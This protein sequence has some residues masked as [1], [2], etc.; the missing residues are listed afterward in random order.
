MN[1]LWAVAAGVVGLLIGL[2]IGLLLG[3]R[4][5]Y[6]TGRSAQRM[7]RELHGEPM[8]GR[9]SF[10]ADRAEL[11]RA[12]QEFG[13]PRTAGDRPARPAPMGDTEDLRKA[14]ERAPGGHPV[15]HTPRRQP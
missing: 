8:K 7:E 15:R 12:S 3:E 1:P 4:V 6:A 13:A 9:P 2:L 11:L 14:F 10:E 5:G